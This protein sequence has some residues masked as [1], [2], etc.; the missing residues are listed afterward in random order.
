MKK[1]ELSVEV[2]R[3]EAVT[4]PPAEGLGPETSARS[5]GRFSPGVYLQKA[6]DLFSISRTPS[7]AG[8][9]RAGLAAGPSQRVSVNPIQRAAHDATYRHSLELTEQ[10][11]AAVA[12]FKKPSRKL[13][14]KAVRAGLGGTGA[15]GRGP[16]AGSNR[17]RLRGSK[18]G[19][20]W[21]AVFTAALF[22]TALPSVPPSLPA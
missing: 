22:A 2:P 9:S 20:F 1:K 13:S 19:S 4:P 21:G 11:R 8:N 6:A 14:E 16:R 15:R 12:E 5:K 17:R 18:R 3:E 10:E 7:R